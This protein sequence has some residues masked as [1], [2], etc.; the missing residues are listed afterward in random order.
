M[1]KIAPRI[2]TGLYK[3]KHLKVPESA[4]P[5]TDRVKTVIFD[6]LGDVT[7]LTC[8]DLFA[9][10][11]NLGIEALSRGV[12]HCTFVESSLEAVQ[13]IRENI[14]QMRIN[15]M[16]ETII[17]SKVEKFLTQTDTT[18]DLIF[19][20][21]PFERIGQF[22]LEPVVKLMHPD[23]VIMLKVNKEMPKLTPKLTI[24][25]QKKMGENVVVFLKKI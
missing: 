21:P 17:N 11:G 12:V 16:S 5:V 18:Y 14:D 1:K 9:G 3:G 7:G 10:S 24:V 19:I 25:R 13:L 15:E 22:N 6:L 2:I 23:S 8:I 4:R 20:D